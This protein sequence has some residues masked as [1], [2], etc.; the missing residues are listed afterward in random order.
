MPYSVKIKHELKD[1]TFIFDKNPLSERKVTLQPKGK[2]ELDQP[3]MSKDV[4]TSLAKALHQKP[5]SDAV[6]ENAQMLIGRLVN[7]PQDVIVSAYYD[8]YDKATCKVDSS[9]IVKTHSM[10]VKDI[11]TRLNASIKM[12]GMSKTERKAIMLALPVATLHNYAIPD[13]SNP[14]ST[15]KTRQPVSMEWTL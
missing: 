14:S 10:S 6:F 12:Q 1:G 11:L 7:L 3:N 15:K 5:T 13:P 9:K 2:A 8:N 4:Q